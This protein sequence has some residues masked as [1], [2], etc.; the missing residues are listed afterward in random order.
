MNPL[1]DFNE[2]HKLILPE[3]SE[4]KLLGAPVH[5]QLEFARYN[6]ARNQVHCGIFKNLEGCH[7]SF[8]TTL[9]QWDCVYSYLLHLV[10][11][12]AYASHDSDSFHQS[13]ILA[14]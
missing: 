3:D 1:L 4:K 8:V 13:G 14:E 2:D 6:I 10:K 11:H 5:V 12:C 9:S 7:L